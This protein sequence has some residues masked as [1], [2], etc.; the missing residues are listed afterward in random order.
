[1]GQ[2]ND[3][4]GSVGESFEHL[5]SSPGTGLVRCRYKESNQR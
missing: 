4:T 1:L 2:D 5:V 3:A